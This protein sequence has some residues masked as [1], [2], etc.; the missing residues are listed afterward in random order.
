M[1]TKRILVGDPLFKDKLDREFFEDDYRDI[2]HPSQ[3]TYEFD[4]ERLKELASSGEYDVAIMPLRGPE[5]MGYVKAHIIAE[6]IPVLI[7]TS[8]DTDHL[9]WYGDAPKHGVRITSKRPM[10]ESLEQL[11]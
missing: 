10:P 11:L 3:L 5:N 6:H 8:R 9:V 4:H 2:F 1:T 7:M